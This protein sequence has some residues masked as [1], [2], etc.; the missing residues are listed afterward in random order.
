MDYQIDFDQYGT[1]IY[2]NADIEVT[3]GGDLIVRNGTGS[4]LAGFAKGYWKSYR[5]VSEQEL[6]AARRRT[7][8][9][10]KVTA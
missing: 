4:R 3:S 9:H 1:I 6:E 5:K 7:A 2:E 8:E 10:D